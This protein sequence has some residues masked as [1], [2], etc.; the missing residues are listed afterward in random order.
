M[1]ASAT[2]SEE[3]IMKIRHHEFVY[4]KT[5]SDEDYDHYKSSNIFSLDVN[6]QACLQAFGS[7]MLLYVQVVPKYSYIGEILVCK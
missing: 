5:G 1:P 2:N 3:V 6:H 4:T 7:D